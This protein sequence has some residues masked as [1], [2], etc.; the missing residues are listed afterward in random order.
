ME[1]PLKDIFA[2]ISY[3]WK[4]ISPQWWRWEKIFNKRFNTKLLWLKIL[5]KLSWGVLKTF[6]LCGFFFNH[7]LTVSKQ[8]SFQKINGCFSWKRV[9]SARIKNMHADPNYTI[10]LWGL[11]TA[12]YTYIICLIQKCKLPLKFNNFKTVFSKQVLTVSE[13]YLI[14]NG[15][16][17]IMPTISQ[18]FRCKSKNMKK[19]IDKSSRCYSLWTLK[20]E[21]CL[22]NRNPRYSQKIQSL[23]DKFLTRFKRT[24]NF[25]VSWQWSLQ[26]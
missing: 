2:S 8:R 26:T 7:L 15:L 20:F 21:R 14:R 9:Q 6:A 22:I 17:R 12:L 1:I 24:V 13:S 18:Q 16:G 10:Q 4:L 3:Y 25:I 11:Y 19:K 23:I 5:E